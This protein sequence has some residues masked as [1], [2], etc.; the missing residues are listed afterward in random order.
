V[1]VGPEGGWGV[2]DEELFKKK[3]V[4]FVTMGDQILRAETA[5]IAVASLLLLGKE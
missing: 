2:R 4:P 1:F 5:S 3:N